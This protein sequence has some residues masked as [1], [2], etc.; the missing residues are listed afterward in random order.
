MRTYGCRR[1]TRSRAARCQLV[2]PLLP[3]PLRSRPLPQFTLQFHMAAGSGILALTS[4]SRPCPELNAG[5]AYHGGGF[6]TADSQ[7]VFTGHIEYLL[8]HG[9]AVVSLEYRM[10]PQ[11][12]PSQLRFRFTLLTAA[13]ASTRS[14]KICWTGTNGSCTSCRASTPRSTRSAT[15]SL[16]GVLAAHRPCSLYVHPS[17]VFISPHSFVGEGLQLTSVDRREGGWPAAPQGKLHRV[18]PVRPQRQVLQGVQAVRPGA[19]G[20]R[21]VAAQEGG[22]APRGA[23]QHSARRLVSSSTPSS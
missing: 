16:A 17:F 7:H 20:P 3:R 10:C 14:A 12:V 15:L 4:Y 5:I 13:S 11:C 22:R 23:R 21:A 2:S 8:D 9:Y 1:R 6:T 18:P 19:S